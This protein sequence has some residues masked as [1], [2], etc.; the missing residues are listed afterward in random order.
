MVGLNERGPSGSLFGR[1][2]LSRPNNRKETDVSL[3]NLAQYLVLPE[4]R[5]VDN[6]RSEGGRVVLFAEKVWEFEVCPKCAT[7]SR[8]VYDRRWVKLRD[9][10]QAA[11]SF[12]ALERL[13]TVEALARR[14]EAGSAPIVVVR[15][16]AR[17]SE[18]GAP[19]NGNANG[20]A[21]SDPEEPT[22]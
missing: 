9:D 13:A 21:T 2:E 11:Y 16:P 12:I 8:S 19:P 3:E 5:F 6:Q 1:F 17:R 14:A 10:P 7:P 15:R 20:A 22:Q 18:P 4:L